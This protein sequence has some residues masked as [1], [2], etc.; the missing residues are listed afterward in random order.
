M[1]EW[2]SNEQLRDHFA[3]HG[4]EMGYQSVDEYDADAQA[5]LNT[6]AY[7]TYHHTAAGEERTGCFDIETGLLVIL[8]MDDEI[9]SFF[10]TDARYIRRL[11]HNNFDG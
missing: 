3:E 2:R 8:N 5:T 9:V 4:R 7:F 6:G 1:A 10:A 11:P